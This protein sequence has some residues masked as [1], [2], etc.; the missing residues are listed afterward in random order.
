MSPGE[1][2][3]E[4]RAEEAPLVLRKF[5]RLPPPGSSPDWDEG[6][7][8][9]FD[10]L[11]REY[12]QEPSGPVGLYALVDDPAMIAS[13]PE[14]V[15]P[16]S[17]LMHAGFLE[18]GEQIRI[19]YFDDA[20]IGPGFPDSPSNEAIRKMT[21]PLE[22][23]YRVEELS[24]SNAT[25]DDVLSLWRREGA[26]AE[27][28][29]RRRASEAFLV[30]VHDDD[31]VVGVATNYLQRN[32]Q[33]RAELWYFRA[34]VARDHRRGNLAMQL[35]LTHRDVLVDRWTSGEDRRGIGIVFEV[36]HEGMQRAFNRGV[37]PQSELTFIGENERGG[38][39]R[40]RYFPGA[41]LSE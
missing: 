6:V 37:A 35:I 9:T 1:G 7:A 29:A 33:L 41:T 10:A 8:R 25:A 27:D 40:V 15:W 16:T 5:W 11:E 39:V 3:L 17:E 12:Q 20:V 26:L 34:Y 32:A 18:S 23:G 28:E 2:T 31:G 38:H 4:V 21:F 14:A 30:A 24:K 19:R 22:P 36:E 13:R